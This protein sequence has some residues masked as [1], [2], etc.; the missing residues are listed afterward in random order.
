MGALDR[1]RGRFGR[2]GQCVPFSRAAAVQC[3]AVVHRMAATPRLAG[4]KENWNQ[5]LLPT[6]QFATGFASCRHAKLRRSWPDVQLV[7]SALHTFSLS[8]FWDFK[9]LMTFIFL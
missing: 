2:A 6:R 7:L 5:P 4:R 1:A 9:C 3:C 8:Y